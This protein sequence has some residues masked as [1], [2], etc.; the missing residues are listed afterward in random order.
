MTRTTLTHAHDECGAEPGCRLTAARAIYDGIVWMHMCVSTFFCLSSPYAAHAHG[1][2]HVAHVP[3]LFRSQRTAPRLCALIL[4]SVEK[5]LVA[6]V[7][8]NERIYAKSLV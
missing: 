3:V 7:S 8:R 4:A 2:P 1:M 5:I 6:R